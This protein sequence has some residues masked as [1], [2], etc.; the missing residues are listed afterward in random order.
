MGLAHN[1]G[2]AK[3]VGVHG[4]SRQALVHCR[5]RGDHHLGRRPLDVSYYFPLLFCIPGVFTSFFF[6]PLVHTVEASSTSGTV[7]C[8]P[9]I[10]TRPAGVAAGG[11]AFPFVLCVAEIPFICW[12]LD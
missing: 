9:N 10:D 3:D 1:F 11:R 2:L 8:I 12:A 4:E 7:T 5:T 6:L